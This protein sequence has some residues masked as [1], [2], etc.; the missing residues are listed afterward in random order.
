MKPVYDFIGDTFKLLYILFTAVLS[1]ALNTVL[2]ILS[3]TAG[4]IDGAVNM[5]SI[6]GGVYLKRARAVLSRPATPS[7]QPKGTLH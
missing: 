5:Y 7:D 3:R 2:F 1:L 6:L 4:F